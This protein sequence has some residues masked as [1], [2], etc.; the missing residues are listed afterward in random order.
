[1]DRVQQVL[2]DLTWVPSNG[3]TLPQLLCDVC[4]VAVPVTG[5]G[6]ALMSTRG[7]RRFGRGNRPGRE[8]H[9]RT[10]VH[11]R[12]ETLR[13][14]LRH[15]CASAE[16]R[17]RRT[18]PTRWP[19]FGPGALDVGMEAIFAF[20]L[21]VGAIRLGVLD[22]YRDA[23]GSL[24]PAQLAGALS[25]ADAATRILLHLQDQMPAGEGL[26]PDLT[27]ADHDRPKCTRPPESS[28]CRP[29]SAS[30]RCCCYCG[31]THFHLS[32]PSWPLR[33]TSYAERFASP[34]ITRIINNATGGYRA[35]GSEV[36]GSPSW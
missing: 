9:G 33:A 36:E 7:T 32:T 3:A 31:P 27:A 5:V 29:L 21:G 22:L 28:P 24:V 6:M 20:P 2:G 30:P 17:L 26:H 35:R 14:C 15:G 16:P 10:A 23:P 1:M 8:H 25:F 19:A 4:A 12:G 11:L 34:R 18:A 13:G